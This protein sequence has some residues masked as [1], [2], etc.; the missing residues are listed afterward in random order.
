[1]F[2]VYALSDPGGGPY[3]YI[4]RTGV[5][6]NKR[7][8]D[9][10]S[11]ARFHSRRGRTLSPFFHWLLQLDTLNLRPKIT[12]LL[13]F[14][15]EDRAKEFQLQLLETYPGLLNDP[16]PARCVTGKTLGTLDT[17]LG[18][19]NKLAANKNMGSRR[20]LMTISYVRRRAA[21]GYPHPELHVTHPLNWDHCRQVNNYRP[22]YTSPARQAS[23]ALAQRKRAYTWRLFLGLPFPEHGTRDHRNT[24]QYYHAT[25]HPRFMPLRDFLKTKPRPRKLFK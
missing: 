18:K 25:R 11:L 2:H 7:T 8:C 19:A 22:T 10:V 4:G 5:D 17:A 12:N 13:S 6:A 20:D 3:R 1:M 9:Y 21:L 15:S 24:L 23:L 16:S 14:S